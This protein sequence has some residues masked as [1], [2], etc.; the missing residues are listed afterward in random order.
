M[1]T[2]Q[3]PGLARL[4]DE[5]HQL[6]RLRR[7]IEQRLARRLTD[8]RRSE[9]LDERRV[10]VD[11]HVARTVVERGRRG[12]GWGSSGV[13]LAGEDRP[14]EADQGDVLEG[15]VDQTGADVTERALEAAAE[16]ARATGDPHGFIR[17][18]D[19]CARGDQ[20]GKGDIRGRGGHAGRVSRRDRRI[21]STGDVEDD[22]PGRP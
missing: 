19:R 13:V 18:G 6:E 14:R 22:D 21:P 8:G 4:E 12:R 9:R 16:E 3:A 5:V 1:V 20:L 17:G 15:R 11:D 10:A 7:K 2:A